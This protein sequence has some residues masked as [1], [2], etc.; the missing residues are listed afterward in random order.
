MGIFES[1]EAARRLS[2]AVELD[3][4]CDVRSEQDSRVVKGIQLADLVAHTASTMLLETL[5]VVK[6]L[7]RA[8]PD[9]GYDEDLE[10]ELGFELWASL[11]YQFFHAG[12]AEKQGERYQGALMEVGTNGL[13]IS[14]S[15]SPELRAAAVER[16][17]QCYLGCIH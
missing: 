3:R 4:Y 11:R 10:L 7:V 16:F 14:Q 8:G 13:Y 15:C 6:K 17:G 9:S 2:A 5:G 1:V 12:S